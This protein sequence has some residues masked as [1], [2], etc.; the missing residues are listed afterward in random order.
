MKAVVRT[1]FLAIHNRYPPDR[2]VADP[3]LNHAFIAEC[4]RLGLSSSIKSLNQQLLNLRKAGD[5]MGLPRSRRT[6]FLNEED[7]RFA[8]E[9]A[10]RYLERQKSVTVDEIICDPE[11]VRE[12]D[13]IAAD[14]APGF[15]P[16][17]YRWAALNLRKAKRLKPELLSRVAPAQTVSLGLVTELDV[18]SISSKQVFTFSTIPIP[19]RLCMWAKLPTCVNVWRSISTTLTTRAWPAG[20]GNTD[21][22]NYTSNY[23]YFQKR[24]QHE[25][26]AHWSQN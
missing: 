26:G 4:Q 18:V 9:I 25:P 11:L 1:A 8:S 7:Y 17:Q 3:E 2:I 6:S 20:F 12:F 15:L 14:L 23:I 22:R 24:P 5:L 10:A 21:L 19:G 16:L 13:A